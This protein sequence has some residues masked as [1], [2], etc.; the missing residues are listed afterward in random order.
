ML[1]VFAAA[2]RREN[3]TSSRLVGQVVEQVSGATGQKHFGAGAIIGAVRKIGGAWWAYPETPTPSSADLSHRKTSFGPSSEHAEIGPE[4]FGIVVCRSVGSVPCILG[5]V[6]RR[7][8]LKSIS[9]SKISGRILKNCP[10]SFSAAE[11]GV[12]QSHVL[13][14]EVGAQSFATAL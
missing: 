11:P 12:I 7:F 1:D 3:Q 9:K 10:S 14:S 6:W 5:L 13:F 4:S 8:R 2:T